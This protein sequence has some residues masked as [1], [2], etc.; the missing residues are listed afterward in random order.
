MSRRMRPRAAVAVALTL[1][2]SP[3]AAQDARQTVEELER[4]VREL[5]PMVYEAH[6]EA[7]AA[8]ERRVLE[9]KIRNQTETDTI[10]VGP[11]RVVTLPDQVDLARE[12]LGGI[13]D[14][15]YAFLTSGTALDDE[16]FTFEWRT[17]LAPIF[18]E[19]GNAN[20]RV[21]VQRYRSRDVVEE[22]V[23]AAI[24]SILIM[25]LDY[26]VPVR[27][28]IAGPIR[29]PADLS[30]TYRQVALTSS[31]AT[32]ACIAGDPMACWAGLG[33]GVTDADRLATWYSEEER[34]RTVWSQMRTFRARRQADDPDIVACV[35]RRDVPAC[36]RV[37]LERLYWWDATPLSQEVRATMLWYALERG[38]EGAWDRL[39]G[40]ID[41]PLAQ[42]L[43]QTSGLTAEELAEGW[44]A[45]VVQ[46]RPE[47]HA[48]LG[49]TR[50]AA[51]FWILI[52]IALAMRS[53]RWRL[54]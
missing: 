51:F 44:R 10:Q 41:E 40:S 38:G 9:E 39:A 29:E 8:R 22:R 30:W 21:E 50:W 24:G 52:L 34:I 4:R 14:E 3:L 12:V 31:N 25:K 1:V 32:R 27:R 13:L 45:W 20:R 7:E 19:D 18:L 46:A 16:L 28:W 2:G 26:D 33:L 15:E 17:P 49:T 23:R 48:V 35:E 11:L 47:V 36:D 53:T 37:I 6:R 43:L 54:G 42:A 5:Q